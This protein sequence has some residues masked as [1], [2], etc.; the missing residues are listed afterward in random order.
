M[1][2]Q[3]RPTETLRQ[4]QAIRAPL[5]LPPW[6]EGNDGRLAGFLRTRCPTHMGHRSGP[7]GQPDPGAQRRSVTK[8]AHIVVGVNSREHSRPWQVPESG[9]R[10]EI[11]R[12][13]GGAGG[14]RRA[15][16]VEAR[17]ARQEETTH[18]GR[19][20]PP[21]NIVGIGGGACFEALTQLWVTAPPEVHR[22]VTNA[23]WV[24][25]GSWQIRETRILGHRRIHD[26]RDGC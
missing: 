15:R 2:Y 11:D 7:V 10:R 21:F 19:S 12:R 16:V 26:G 4:T 5:D 17:A 13:F 25:P 8:P 9:D 20:G 23:A 14:E 6:P 3:R 24:A 1:S 18:G 22:P